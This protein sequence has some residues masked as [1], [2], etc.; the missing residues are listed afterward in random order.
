MKK[1]R[2][3]KCLFLKYKYKYLCFIIIMI[4]DELLKTDCIK[5]GNFKLKN[6]EISK[7]YFDMR[8]LYHT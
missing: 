1:S 4:I 7:Y 3:F 6:G 2:S 5:Y 8:V